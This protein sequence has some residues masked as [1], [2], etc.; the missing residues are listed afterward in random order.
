MNT[1][2]EHAFESHVEETLLRQGG[3]RRIPNA[4]WDA[5]RAL[6]P[7]RICAFLEATQPKPWA[8][9]RALHAAGLESLLVDA[10]ARELDLKGTLHV[11]RHGFKFYGKTFRMAWFKPA[12]AL[13]EEVL[14]LYGKNELTITRQAPCHPKKRDTVDLLFALNGLPVATCELKN[15]GT[16]QSWRHAVRQYRDDRD[17]RAPLFRFKTR[18]LVH[19]AADP[20]EVHMSTRIGGAETR[21]L[22]FNRGSHPGEVRCGAGNPQHPSGYRTGYFWEEVLE[23]ES[24]LDVIGHFM[25]V[26]TKDEKVDDDKGR[27]RRIA[28]ETL[29]FPRYHQLDAVRKLVA[30]AR[31]EGAGRSYLIQHSA[32][33]G[34][35]NSISWLSH[36]LASLHDRE[37]R[38]VFDCV[39]VVTDRR[40]LDR[41]LQDA[42]YQIEHAQGVV[43]A[44]DRDSRQLAAA[45]IDGTRIVVTT[46]QKFPFVLRGL[47]HAAGAESQ[48][49]A[50]ADET[51][52]AKAWEAEIAKRRYAVIV[53][54]A[55]SSQSG[56][57]AREFKAILGAGAGT[58]SNA[59]PNPGAD[60]SANPVAGAG[61]DASVDPGTDEG[62]NP[63]TDEGANLGASAGTDASTHPDEGADAS[64]APGTDPDAGENAEDGQEWE[65]RL[66]QIMAS[67]GRQP[68]L[69]FFAFTATPKGKTLEL[70]GRSDGRSRS[71]VRS[72]SDERRPDERRPG[73]CRSN[74][75]GTPEAFHLYSMRQAIEEGFILDVLA[76]YTTYAAY[77][78]LLKNVEDDPRLPRKKAARALAK[79]ASLHPHNVEQK[80]EVIVEHFRRNVMHRIGGRA[81]AMVVTPS[82]LHAVRYKLSFE[83][84][85]AGNGYTDV[86]PLVAFSGTVRDPDT[87]IEYTEPGM[88]K[89]VV[90]GRPIG[91]GA[92][93]D[94]FDSPDYQ[95]L[96]VANKYQTGFDQPLLCA[97]YVDKRLDGVQAVQTLSRL[98][99]TAPGKEAPFVLD[100]VNDAEDVRRAFKPYYDKTEMAEASKPEI[101]EALKHALDQ[102]RIYHWSEVEAFARVFYKPPER[103]RAADHAHLQRRLQPAV[104]RFAGVEEEDE[105]EKFREKLSGYVG[106]YA[107]L[108][109]ILP[110]TDHEQEMLYSFG[111][112]LLPHLPLDR[113]DTMVGI[114]D[115]VAL[116]YY[117]LD[118]VHT[119]AIGVAEG[120]P[121]YVK[122]PTETGTR[123]AQDDQ[124]PLSEIIETLN[125]RFGTQFTEEDRLFFDQIKERA[126]N[127]DAVVRT[128]L[129]NPLDR[130]EMGVRGLIEDLMIERMGEND[131]I[132]TRYLSDGEFQGSAFPVLAREI[133]E[134]V[135]ARQAG[136][137]P[138]AGIRPG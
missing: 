29:I 100:F 69:S 45:L 104:D 47:L 126:C 32:G 107:Y 26:E 25:F 38:K 56:E 127:S 6:F 103:Q 134:T 71:D 106:M 85:L 87:G 82:R 133:F 110:Y 43:K 64:A 92:L 138:D 123:K 21:F 76:S 58:D 131:R 90:T 120:E 93:P 75:R 18:A 8:Q 53:D 4:G 96:L 7:A 60:E 115:E 105:R 86:R 113:D 91:E 61:A 31:E 135:R 88:N 54:E 12:H 62:A 116:Q 10:L 23:R 15:P 129:A 108:S 136:A 111:R 74:G 27:A 130:F 73:G 77:Y 117:R 40:V 114:R 65:D 20:D 30:A 39:V 94:R 132:V 11:L 119:G 81:K 9:M 48:E 22:P 49:T 67:R 24:F 55:H 97:M 35:T 13:N 122:P 112:F 41:Q 2:S 118:R 84:Y 99:R 72:C 42:I 89:D 36:R 124:A 98:N 95:V 125:E 83:R 44:I 17:P 16:G 128:A 37:D 63:G 46:L 66:N 52:R 137:P 1:A 50:T 57:T 102:T 79:F 121:E 5:E 78:G 101:L 19:F 109:Q 3:W 51:A 34:K 80:T 33:S 70:F 59:N 68:N 14:A 28:R